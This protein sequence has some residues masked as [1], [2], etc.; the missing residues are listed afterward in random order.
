M[1]NVAS[2]PERSSG[3]LGEWAYR[4]L[5]EEIV[6]H[7]LRPGAALQET[8]L[9]ERMGLSRTPVREALRRLATDGFVTTFPYKGFFVAT[10][11]V[12]DLNAVCEVRLALE[13][14]AARRA[15]ES[16]TG[17]ER[18]QAAA[19]LGDLDLSP[20]QTTCRSERSTRELMDSDRRIHTHIHACSH[21]RYMAETLGRYLNLAHR[22]WS[23]VIDRVPDL[24]AAIDQHRA[25]L[26]ALRDGDPSRAEENM[27]EHILS[28]DR[29]VRTLLHNPA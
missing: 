26:E 20:D 17:P 8:E 16:A 1:L 4:V 21:N 28:Y 5:L 15:V 3:N 18:E 11:D 19:L 12:S 23:L 27:R 24:S 22:I 10:I 29:V 13:P 7:D 25:V 6:F 2:T 9:A 14:L